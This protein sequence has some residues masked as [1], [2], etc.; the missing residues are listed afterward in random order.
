MKPKASDEE[1]GQRRLGSLGTRIAL[2]YGG[3]V[4]LCLLAYSIAVVVFFTRHVET[5]PDRRVHEDVELAGRAVAVSESGLPVW[6]GGSPPWSGV[7]EEEGG[8][9]WLEVWSLEGR[10]H[11]AD[12]T[13]DAVDLGPGPDGSHPFHEQPA[14]PDARRAALSREAEIGVTSSPSARRP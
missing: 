13:A 3:L 2:W 7:H 1:S 14:C 4:A 9:H 11:L 5:E 8:G 10:R 12:G 6:R